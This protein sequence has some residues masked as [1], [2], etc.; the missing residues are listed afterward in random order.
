M[1]SLKNLEGKDFPAFYTIK[2]FIIML[3]GVLDKPFF[4]R[5]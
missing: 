5:I 3:D 2:D 4:T 1:L